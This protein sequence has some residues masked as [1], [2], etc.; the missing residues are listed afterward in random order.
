MMVNGDGSSLVFGNDDG[1]SWLKA[2]GSSDG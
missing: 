2:M 1:E